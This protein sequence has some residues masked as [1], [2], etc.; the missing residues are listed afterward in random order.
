MY[1]LHVLR[2]ALELDPGV[3][4]LGV[5]PEDD[6]VD[7]FGMLY[8]RRDALVPAHRTQADIEIE[9]LAERH[10]QRA[11]AAADRS[12]E[13]TLDPHQELAERVHGLVREPVGEVVVRFLPGEDF[14]PF[15]A[16]LAAIGLGDRGVEDAH[17]RSPDVGPGA[18]AFDVGNDRVVRDLELP[19]PNLDRLPGGRNLRLLELGGGL[20]ARSHDSSFADESS[21]EHRLLASRSRSARWTEPVTAVIREDV[22][23]LSRP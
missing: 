18:V 21:R 20:L 2:A 7:L 5:L 9:D 10:V 3:D 1:L 19:V 11:D 15:E 23:D 4:V 17:A 6:H 12:G 16:A 13:R 14:H 8:R 22:D